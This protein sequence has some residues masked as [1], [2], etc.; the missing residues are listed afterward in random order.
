MSN[1]ATLDQIETEISKLNDIFKQYS[2][3][4]VD[5]QSFKKEQDLRAKMYEC[6]VKK[7]VLMRKLQSLQNSTISA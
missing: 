4:L 2:K 6:E 5:C 3:D 7:R 1:N